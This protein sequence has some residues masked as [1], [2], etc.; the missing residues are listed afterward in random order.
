MS[1]TLAKLVAL[2]HRAL[3]WLVVCRNLKN[4]ILFISTLSMENYQYRS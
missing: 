1:I 4:S 2:T 3:F